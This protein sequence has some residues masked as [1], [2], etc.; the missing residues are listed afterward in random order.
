MVGDVHR[1]T[2]GQPNGWFDKNSPRV[3]LSCRAA[4]KSEN[5]VNAVGLMH[6]NRIFRTFGAGL[7]RA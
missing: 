2:G 3:G 7:S 6:L 1:T 4:L 5:F